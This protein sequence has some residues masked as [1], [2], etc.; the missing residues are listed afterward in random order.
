MYVIHKKIVSDSDV[1]TQKCFIPSSLMKNTDLKA[2]NVVSIHCGIRS[3]ICRVF[4]LPATEPDICISV[5]DTVSFESTTNKNILNCQPNTL[6][7]PD[8][9][10]IIKPVVFKK[11]QISLIL[12]D[13]SQKLIAK[14][15]LLEEISFM[16]LQNTVVKKNAVVKCSSQEL[17]NQFHI[18]SILVL[19][20]FH[21]ENIFG[22]VCRSSF[23]EV[24]EMRTND[25]LKLLK[26][27][28]TTEIAEMNN[29][30][31]L[32]KTFLVQKKSQSVIVLGPSGCGKSSLVKKF[33]I[34]F[35]CYVLMIDGIKE[36][37][38]NSDRCIMYHKQLTQSSTLFS[39]QPSILFIDHID[40]I[41]SSNAKSRKSVAS[42]LK[43]LRNLQHTNVSIV[44]TA[45]Q[46]D[47]LHPS[48]SCFFK[49]KIFLGIP[50]FD[51]RKEILKTLTKSYLYEIDYEKL[52]GLIPG[53]LPSDIARL[54]Q[55]AVNLKTNVVHAN[56]DKDIESSENICLT[57]Q[58][59]EIALLS[60]APSVLKTSEWSLRVKPVYWKDIGGVREIK[61][62]LQLSIELPLRHP[63]IFEKV[64]LH[65]PRGVLLFGP[66]GC[67]KTTLARGL[68]T[69]CNANF[70]AAN[71]SQIYS[72]YV[73]ESEKNIAK[74]FYQARTSA[75]SIIFL[76]E[77]DSLVGYR[78][79]NSKQQ[80]VAE[81]VLSTL[82]NEMDGLG[83]KSQLG[84]NLNSEFMKRSS[85]DEI[86]GKQQKHLLDEV[87]VVAATNR[88]DC[89][90]EALL[91]PGRFDIILYVPP[92]NSE[93]RE[94][95]LQT[96]TYNM[97]LQDIDFKKIVEK[98]NNFTGA[99][100]KNLC[101]MAAMNSLKQ[102]LLNAT[103]VTEE[104]F[105]QA[106]EKIKPSVSIEQIQMYE[107][108][109]TKY[110]PIIAE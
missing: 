73:G 27:F 101:N 4:P 51:E 17:A 96:V 68:A 86:N 77:L 71:P 69:E 98:T 48:I 15:Q 33:C 62:R 64:D 44:A 63:E 50:N 82:L 81:K 59:F 35:K 109:A 65:C 49:K 87:I 91:R 102:D 105:M 108:L 1:N 97:P 79:L 25:Q 72:S 106:L 34:D 74:L 57:T 39:D 90:D 8:D 107:K 18:H 3:Y 54:I 56:D 14:G 28:E 84:E 52:A 24:V 42:L 58:D 55:E 83:V 23:V 89:I 61:E 75:P 99:D 41:A 9:L 47:L 19:E 103:H 85:M 29:A 7:I 32:L 36:Q 2:G 104:H 100:L 40:E 53:F 60:V 11:L 46:K 92:P 38:F 13:N 95:I 10:N 67:C 70:F 93:E 30:I 80:G 31:E 94:S 78:N 22:H 43:L 6:V 20:T 37:N 12:E 88:P 66:P 16:L 21:A 110:G 45:S 26:E 76:D 5:D